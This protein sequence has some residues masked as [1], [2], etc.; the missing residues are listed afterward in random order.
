MRRQRLGYAILTGIFVALLLCWGC[1]KKGNPIPP[2]IVPPPAVGD[3]AVLSTERGIVLSWS[4]PESRR[5]I[6][7]FRI[8]RTTPVEA[9]EACPGCPQDYR[10][11]RTLSLGD[12]RLRREGERGF[13]HLDADVLVSHYY[14]YRV[15]AGGPAGI[16]RAPANEAGLVHGAASRTGTDSKK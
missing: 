11:L 6:G 15:V 16:C 10:P 3:L 14:A 9:G 2:R 13:S 4:L 7:S 1:G 5:Q 12:E 8:S